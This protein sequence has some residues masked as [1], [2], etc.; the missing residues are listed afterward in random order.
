MTAKT[1]SET[2][3]TGRPTIGARASNVKA[4]KINPFDK[5]P[6]FAVGGEDDIENKRYGMQPGQTL[7]GR[8]QGTKIVKGEKLLN[9]EST[10]HMLRDENTKLVYGIWDSK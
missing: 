6:T 2:Q 7:C 8:Y 3:A 5:M 1:T 4:E 10:L 9:G